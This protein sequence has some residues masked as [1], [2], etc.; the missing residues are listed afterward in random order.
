MSMHARALV[1]IAGIMLLSVLS[2]RAAIPSEAVCSVNAEIDSIRYEG[3]DGYL[4]RVSVSFA[5]SENALIKGFGEHFFIQ[6][7]RG[8]A[9]LSVL[10]LDTASTAGTMTGTSKKE[11]LKLVI[12]LHTPDLFRTYEGMFH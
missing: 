7:D 10:Y 8:W 2:T 11:S 1:L 6:T 4:I 9:P 3:N 12:P 5:A